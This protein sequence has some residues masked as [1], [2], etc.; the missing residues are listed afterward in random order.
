[1]KYRTLGKTGI[2]VSEIGFGSWQLANDPHMW[3]GADLE[4]SIKCLYKYVE[5][6]GNFID[7]AWIYGYDEKFPD[8]HP[9]EEL[10]GKFMA[11]SGNRGKVTVATKIPGKN[12]KWPA[13]Q[14]IDIDEV[15]PEDWIISCVEDSLRTLR[16]ESLDLVQFHVWQDAFVDRDEWKQT[17]QKLTEDGKVKHWGIS[18]NDYQPS[19]CIRA[20]DTGLIDTVQFI[21][22]IFHQK[23]TEKLLPYALKNN[24]GLIARV[25]FDEGG[26]VGKFNS[27][28]IFA[29]GDFREEYFTKDR[30]AELIK[31]T[32][33]L[34]LLFGPE[35][36]TF[37]EL[38]LKYIL[39][40]DA[41]STVIPGMRRLYQVESN[42]AASGDRLSSELMEKLKQHAW[43]RNFYTNPDPS[44]EA[45]GF[46]EA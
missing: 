40:F 42:L 26:L 45:T 6:G 3:V 14:G 44:M 25:P 5:L 17:I 1:M 21:F 24:I 15:F 31:R 19:N 7:T 33:G 28:T 2:R 23:P 12:M 27:D 39:S 36:S 8:K 32:E 35:A 46:I 22:N 20:L 43:E 11:E 30:L 38:A 4:E 18:A 37:P 29:K 41:I 16:T 13:W 34:K 10:I 9:S